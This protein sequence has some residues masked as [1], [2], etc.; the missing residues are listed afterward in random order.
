MSYLPLRLN[1]LGLLEGNG[2]KR[3][4]SLSFLE[5]TGNIL[6]YRFLLGHTPSP[7]KVLNSGYNRIYLFDVSLNRLSS[8]GAHE[9]PSQPSD[10]PVN[11]RSAG[12]KFLLGRRIVPCNEFQAQA[13][14]WLGEAQYEGIN[15]SPPGVF[16]RPVNSPTATARAT[17]PTCPPTIH[18]LQPVK[19]I[20]CVYREP[21]ESFSVL[22]MVEFGADVTSAMTGQG[23]RHHRVELK[24]T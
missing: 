6:L 1:A 11:I 14:L 19:P 7:A 5:E 22:Y 17:A 16:D 9:C 3:V 15:I 2:R 18:S 4:H 10:S 24:H 8:G 13:N 23:T 20:M 12:G 21:C